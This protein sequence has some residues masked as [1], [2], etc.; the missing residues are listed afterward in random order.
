MFSPGLTAVDW[1]CLARGAKLS[2]YYGFPREDMSLQIYL[3]FSVGERERGR[4]RVVNRNKREAV[5]WRDREKELE[6]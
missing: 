4:K 5:A 1:L 2:N 3:S 6:S